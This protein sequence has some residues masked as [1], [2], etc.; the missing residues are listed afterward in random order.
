MPQSIEID[1]G[2]EKLGNKSWAHSLTLDLAGVCK[3][4]GMN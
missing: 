2:Q 1:D 4:F 3:S